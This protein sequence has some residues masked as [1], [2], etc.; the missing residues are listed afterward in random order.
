VEGLQSWEWK[1]WPLVEHWLL[2]AL[3]PCKIN[4][5][6]RRR[7]HKGEKTTTFLLISLSAFDYKIYEYIG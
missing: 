5:K 4:L 2:E 1:G 3:I 7:E 6:G